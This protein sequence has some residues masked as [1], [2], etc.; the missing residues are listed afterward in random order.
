MRVW[1]CACEDA[2]I[3]NDAFPFD[4]EISPGEFINRCALCVATW[5]FD[6]LTLEFTMFACD[7]FCMVLWAMFV[8][9]WIVRETFPQFPKITLPWNP[10]STMG[11]F[12]DANPSMV[13]KRIF[14]AALQHLNR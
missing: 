9:F 11:V 6:I 7:G 2:G 13:R 5:T 3:M 10:S 1:T 12:V 8:V 14:Q 4:C